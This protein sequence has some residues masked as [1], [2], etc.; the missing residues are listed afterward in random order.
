MATGKRPD[1]GMPGRGDDLPS[2]TPVAPTVDP[3]S[4]RRPIVMGVVNV[5]PDSFSDGGQWFEPGAAIRH[6]L[7]LWREGAQ[8]LDVGGEST[9]PGAQRPDLSEELRRVLPVVGALVGEGCVV[10]VD[11]M[12]AA[13]AEAAV[14]AG[15][16][17]I[18]DVSG[19]LADP[20]MASFA[21][22]TDLPFIAMHWR[23]HSVDMQS[24]AVYDDVVTDVVTEL[25]ERRDVLLQAG[26]RPEHLI[27]DPGLGFAKTAEHNWA[28]LRHLGDLHA[29]GQP[30]LLGTSRKAFLGRVGRAAGAE[31]LPEAR[32]VATA[33][34]SFHAALHGVW[35]LR[36][37]EVRGTVDALDVAQAMSPTVSQTVSQSN[38][39]A[40]R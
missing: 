34:T 13:V 22:S 18:N 25:G 16:T 38:P 32:D 35:G 24:R 4:W 8:I 15:A 21:A 17:F 12:R 1:A 26:I 29:L 5:T 9:R 36:V 6:G 40:P 27:L 37:H 19:G 23:G 39:G 30:L 14:A 33:V 10:S 7:A 2:P 28:L 3:G 31:R 11:T 20:D